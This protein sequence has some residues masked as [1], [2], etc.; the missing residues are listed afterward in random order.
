M[1]FYQGTPS[2]P[3]AH[4]SL[5]GDRSVWPW[6]FFSGSSLSAWPPSLTDT[7]ILSSV[8]LLGTWPGPA[9]RWAQGQG[10]PARIVLSAPKEARR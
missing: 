6:V 3:C 9:G 4:L 5:A 7:D 1:V 10:S 2:G 8:H